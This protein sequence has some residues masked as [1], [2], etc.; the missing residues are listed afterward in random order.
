[1]MSKTSKKLCELQSELRSFQDIWHGGFFL[2][3][4]AD[5]AFGL[6]GLTSFIG[7]SHAIYLACIKPFVNENTTVLEIGCGRG[8]WTKLMLGAR[9][10][11]CLDALPPEH[12]RFDDY[13]GRH[14]HIH[15][16]TVEDFSLKEVPLAVIDF[17]FSYDALCHVSFDGI[18]EYARNLFLRMRGGAHG[19]WMVADY[20]KYNEFVSRQDR[21]N[22][23]QCLLPRKKYPLLGKLLRR[24]YCFLNRWN[25][26]RHHLDFLDEHENEQACPGR[27][28][29]AGLRRT[30]EM[31]ERNGFTIVQ[32]DMG[33]DYRSPLIHFR[34]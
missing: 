16:V 9:E 34:K 21:Y 15:Y 29:H 6:W 13:V 25:A 23:L 20:H 2:G 31:L 32:A 12:N 11:Y 33:F 18:S 7:V 27:W 10:I 4:P 22:V 1:M 30:C 19:F 26:R 24:F 17:V 14:D 5:P 28:Y 8:A 3:D